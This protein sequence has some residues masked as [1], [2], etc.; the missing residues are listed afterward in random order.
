MKCLISVLIQICL[1]LS[2]VGCKEE[3]P[4]IAACSDGPV[5]YRLLNENLN[6]VAYLKNFNQE[7]SLTVE[8]IQT[9]DEL[10]SELRIP[11]LESKIDF[12]KETLLVGIV[13]THSLGGVISQSVEHQCAKKEI[14]WHATVKVGTI[15]STGFVH[16]FAIIPKIADETTVRLIAERIDQ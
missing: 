3:K 4:Q 16:V 13:R 6:P 5:N 14:R 8:V 11:F 2:F 7:D 9:A 12:Q 1:V 15:P 10:F